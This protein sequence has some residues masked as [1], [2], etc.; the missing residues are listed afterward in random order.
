MQVFLPLFFKKKYIRSFPGLQTHYMYYTMYNTNMFTFTTPYSPFYRYLV[1]GGAYLLRTFYGGYASLCACETPP[2]CHFFKKNVKKCT[3]NL[4]ISKKSTTFAPV[5]KKI[6]PIF[7]LLLLYTPLYAQHDTTRLYVNLHMSAPAEDSLVQACMN[8]T[9]SY[10]SMPCTYSSVDQFGLPVTLSGKIYFPREGLPKR[11]VLQ[12]H[13]TVLSNKE[14]PSMCDMGEAVLRDKGYALVMPDYL[15]YGITCDRNHPYLCCELAA[16]NT[17]DMLFAAQDFLSK[18]NRQPQNDSIIIVG[19][20]QGAQ[21]A[22]ATLRLLETQYPHIP[23][24]QCFAGSGPYDV[25]RTYDV[26]IANDNVGLQFT[27][28][29]LIMGTSWGYNL[30]LDPNYFMYRKTVRHARKYIF[31]KQYTATN[32]TIFARM[33]I[34]HKVSKL[35]TPQGMNKALPETARLY[36]GLLRSSIVHVSETDTILGEWTPR[37]P[38]FLMHSY[39]DKGVP[40]ENSQSLQLMLETKGVQNVEYDFGDYGDHISSL[41]RF[42]DI[43]TKRL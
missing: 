20:S 6:L 4:H 26:T 37:T 21:S 38:L 27:V 42:L 5:M 11:I 24:K 9:E 29:L 22:L 12:P 1:R 30:H 23:V 18:L 31:S 2:F 32:V 7:F 10:V 35:M 16:R 13:Y 19:F 43:L 39:T 40:F 3:K 41:F 25:A 36:N 8:T 33:G 14:V 15:G 34:S 17:V 28:P